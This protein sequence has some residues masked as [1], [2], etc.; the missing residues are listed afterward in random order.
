VGGWGWGG[1]GGWGDGVVFLGGVSG[2]V[3]CGG[4][5]CVVG[6]FGWGVG[7]FLVWVSG[8][9]DPLCFGLPCSKGAVGP[10]A[11]SVEER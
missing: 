1:G 10:S 7:G 11:D 8:C 4:G 6:W 3:G 5:G 2:G 9:Y